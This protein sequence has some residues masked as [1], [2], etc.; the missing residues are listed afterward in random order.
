M[1]TGQTIAG[2]YRLNRILGSGGMA[3]VWSATNVFTE[4]EFAIKFML[5]QVARTPESARRFLLEAKVSGRINHPNIIEVIDVGQA[6]DGSLFLVM[7]LLGGMSLE[8]AVRRQ[9]PPMLVHEFF[10]FMRD[11]AEALAAAH[12]SGVI[13]RDLKPTNIYLHRDRDGQ[14]VPKVLDFGVSKILEEGN[15]A[16]TIV[17]TILGSP[18]YMSPEQAMGAEGI[19]GR[20]DVFAFGAILF[21]ALCGQRAYAAPNLNALIVTIATGRPKSIDELAPLLPESVRSL[22]RDCLVTDKNARLAS[23]DRVVERL[24]RILLELA[25]SQERLPLPIRRG[26][27]T[28]EPPPVEASPLPR[29]GVARGGASP[30]T[31]GA[32]FR[33]AAPLGNPTSLAI[34][35]S[36]PQSGGGPSSVPAW[37]ATARPPRTTTRLATIAL[38]GVVVAV[39]VF[40]ASRAASGPRGAAHRV[41]AAP[42]LPSVGA[43]P[44][45]APLPAIAPGAA[46]AS[47]AG[48]DS[49]DT[50]VVSVDSLPVAARGGSRSK[51]T[52]KL[53]VAA[54]PGA[55]AVSVDGVARGE[56]PV[57]S[58]ELSPGIHRVECV[59]HGGAAQSVKV[60]VSEGAE[61]HYQFALPQ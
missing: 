28:P 34:S 14:V 43:A 33:A 59:P 20:T 13:H 35:A 55:C 42:P 56:T 7:E 32:L 26:D 2:K 16:L 9:T 15:D 40:A 17:G 22:V 37:L 6:E 3:S 46:G 45:V 29:E 24:D 58:L 60:L 31:D 18:L 25:T 39:G 44:A 5:P 49:S 30:V 1:Q 57:P 4:R 38:A 27:L 8:T 41:P 52:G 12:R 48:A 23:F 36:I 19:D 11:V 50:P 10:V 61:A 47:P 54:T 21:E 53:T 51:A